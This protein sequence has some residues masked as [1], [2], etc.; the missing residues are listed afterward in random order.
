MPVIAV[1]F[2]LYKSAPRGSL[3]WLVLAIGV[4]MLGQRLGSL[5]LAPAMTGF[6]GAVAVVPFALFAAR[7]KGAP[8][9]IVLLL[10]AFWCLVPGALSFVN[11]SEVAATGHANLTALLD[12]CM[13]IFSI[14]LGLLVGASLHRG[15]RY[16][17]A[18]SR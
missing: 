4:A 12:T 7:F 14:A 5:F 3:I 1:G 10:A 17:L 15:M 13:A 8:S 16:A 9:A 11:V 6:V 2:Y 18:V